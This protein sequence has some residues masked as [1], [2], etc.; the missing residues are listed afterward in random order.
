MNFREE[1]KNSIEIAGPSAEQLERM[2]NNVLAQTAA[3]AKKALPLKRIAAVGSAVAACAV[4][5][6]AAVNILP[7]LSSEAATG[8]A[9]S[10]A[11]STA[12]AYMDA[13]ADDN[14]EISSARANA[15]GSAESADDCAEGDCFSAG[16]DFSA[17][18]L[19]ENTNAD[20]NEV[21]ASDEEIAVA[22]DKMPDEP[23]PP[24]LDNACYDAEE[25]APAFMLNADFTTLILEDVKYILADDKNFAPQGE[26]AREL[27][28]FVPDG[29]EYLLEIYDDGCI[30]LSGGADGDLDIIGKYIKAE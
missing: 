5:S 6:V 3:P 11:D 19:Q 7:R 25:A 10:A 22:P 16:G 4:I 27:T 1:Y 24:A 30:V 15:E 12:I 28:I 29:T 14:E 21:F 17:Y 13:S 23:P 18:E 20:A 9:S 8:G 2:K 26:I